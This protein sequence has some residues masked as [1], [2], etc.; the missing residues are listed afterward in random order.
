MSG[1][2]GI[3]DTI[4]PR[5]VDASHLA[6]MSD[7]LRHRGPD[8]TARHLGPGL[9]LVRHHLATAEG[10]R[11][12]PLRSADGALILALD[13]TIDNLAALRR[14]LDE[15]GLPSAGG[16]TETLFDAWRAWGAGCVEHLRGSFALAIAEPSRG[17]LFLARDPLGTKPLHYAMTADGRLLFGSELKAL[18]AHPGLRKAI[19][20]ESVEDYFTFGYVPDPRTIFRGIYRLSAG[21]RLQVRRGEPFPAEQAW[22]DLEFSGD[23]PGCADAAAR[24]LRE[25]LGAAI[26]PYLCHDPLPSAFLSG[27]IDSSAVVALL[28]GQATRPITTCA[29]GFS[30]VDYDE[31]AWARQVAERYGTDHHVASV[32]PQDYRIIDRLAGLYDEPFADSSAL[33]TYHAC[34]LARRF[35]RLVLSGDGGD[36][37]LAG[38]RR[39]RHHLAEE[40]LR[41]R[42]PSALRQPLFRALGAAYPRLDR[43]PRFLRARAT[44]QALGQDSTTGYLH[45]VSICHGE[46]RRTLFSPELRRQLSGYHAVEVFRRHLATAPDH[47]LSRVQ[48]LDYKTYLPGDILTKVDRASMAHGLEVRAPLLDPDLVRWMATLPPETKLRDGEGKHVFRQALGELLPH[49]VLYRRKRGFGVPLAAWFRGPLRGDLERRLRHGS[50]PETGLFDPAAVA[51]LV[52]E[53]TGGRLDHSAALWALLMFE[54]FFAATA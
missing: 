40:A 49:D 33:P 22:W 9:G 42:M 50:L 7:R 21:H 53:H 4:G 54:S 37:A 18:L 30:E 1:L 48:Y 29:I 46:Q 35:G 20:P 27:G 31:T 3:F 2:A 8:H 14:Q 47:P 32:G 45:A 5:P 12:P 11:A 44:F 23:G 39:Y 25:R 24:E 19:A 38:Y 26:R 17:T 6:R 43:A 10:E 52:A 13:G 51:R 34:A 16:A 15:A 36:E 28:A 41:R